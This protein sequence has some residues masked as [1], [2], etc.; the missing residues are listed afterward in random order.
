MAGRN[1]LVDKRWPV[2][3]PFLLQDGNKNK[4]Q[5]VEKCSLG[6]KTLL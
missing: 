5:L 4:I 3:R 6:L 2:V 1:N